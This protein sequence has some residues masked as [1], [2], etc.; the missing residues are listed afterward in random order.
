MSYARSFVAPRENCT[1]GVREQGNL[2]TSFLD[3][4]QIY[5]N[6][7]EQADDLRQFQDG[8][9]S[10]FSTNFRSFEKPITER[11]NGSSTARPGQRPLW[12][13]FRPA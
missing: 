9:A 11:R 4:S 10:H 7:K 12:K 6:D 8:M 1:L 5:G 13:C 3:G 2:V